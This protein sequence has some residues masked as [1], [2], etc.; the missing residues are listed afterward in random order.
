MNSILLRLQKNSFYILIPLVL[1]FA[2]SCAYLIRSIL[3]A[4]FYPSQKVTV[5]SNRPVS[6]QVQQ[7]TNKS[8]NIY[9][10]MVEGNL[11]RG[12]KVVDLP[13]DPNA[14]SAA[15]ALTEDVPG[16]DEMILTGTLSGH[17]SFA[18]ATLKEKDKEEADEYRIGEKVSGYKIKS[19]AD[20]YAVLSKN[21]INLKVEIGQTIK[22]AKEVYNVSMSAGNKPIPDQDAS[23]VSSETKRMP[24]SRTDFEKYL[25]NPA[26][27]YKDAR[28]GPNLVNGKIDGYKIYQVAPSHIFAQLGAKGGDIVKRVNGMPLNETEKMLEIWAAI[29][30]S[31]KVT[32]DLV[33]KEKIITYEFLIRN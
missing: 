8:V 23:L 21:G 26:D 6:F 22:E 10:D 29:K 4:V 28:F 5:Q 7:E 9:E 1:F 15:P 17:P 18:R 19:I 13:V 25:R 14:A 20:H 31:Q 27:L 24:I 3:I 32:V 16:A 30:N 12:R 11:I 33:R 2:Y